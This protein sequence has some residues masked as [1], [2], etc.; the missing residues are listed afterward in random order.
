M[1]C[2]PTCLKIVLKY[3]GKNISLQKLRELSNISREGVSVKSIKDAAEKLGFECLG[4]KLTFDQLKQE[5]ELFPCI[6]HWNQN[7]FVVLYKITKSRVYVS[8]PGIGLINYSHGDFL[9]HWIGNSKKEGVALF[10][11]FDST[12]FN[13]V[14]GKERSPFRFIKRYFTNKKRL[15]VPLVV[16]L[17]IA[18]LIQLVFPFL[19][20][21]IVDTGIKDKNI[22]FIYLI[23]IA[24]LSLIS[25]RYIVEFVR[26]RML[27]HLSTR[28]NIEL[29][30][31]FL[32][33]LMKLP[34]SF[35]DSKVTGDLIQRISD[36]GRIENF[37]SITTLNFI[38]SFTLVFFFGG[39][40]FYYDPLIFFVFISAST[41]YVLY[42]FYFFKK[43]KVLDYKKFQ[44]L[45]S[46]QESLVQIINGMGEIKLNNWQ[47]YK[48]EEW[49]HIQE[50]LY[51]INIKSLNLSQYQNGGGAF[52]RETSNIIIT[53]ISAN[54]VIEGQITLGIMIAIQY[55]VGQLNVP[56]N[57]FLQFSTQ[58]QDA[59]ISLNRINEIHNIEEESSNNSIQLEHDDITFNEL[60]FRYPGTEAVV[61]SR[62]N[63]KVEKGRTTAIVGTSGS[64]KTTLLKLILKFYEPTS[65]E[66]R[67]GSESLAEIDPNEWRSQCGAVMQDGFIFSDTILKNIVGTDEYD[68]IGFKNALDV[69]NLT[70]YVNGLPLK[71]HSKIGSD[72]SSISGGQ[73]Q[74]LLIARAIYKNPNLILFDEATSSLDA[75]NERNIMEKIYQFTESMTVIIVA[76]R[77]STVKRADNIIVL[78]SGKVIEQGKHEDLVKFKGQ[79]YE[80]I[81][82]QLE[83]GD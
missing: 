20:Q 25:G 39:V 13:E 55:I 77:L 80:L 27:I 82:N 83:L 47:A 60:S 21:E 4:S 12:Q 69:A 8:D 57:S 68:P 62:I 49:K 65:G 30:E 73:R 37:F 40:L 19:T 46:N 67:I 61:L 42:V 16:C 58:V 38:F 10:M 18:S 2:G 70:D 63:L 15:I 6:I 43:R 79:Y 78:E 72:G 23:L 44:T 45:S 74:R 50:K 56:L 75:K 48:K 1:D 3:Y 34:F 14:S 53:F 41:L 31:D 9:N 81:K 66:I 52:I 28:I 24:Q 22:R 71:E 51:D 54:A 35:F 76:H 59:S 11:D 33:K 32:G 36:H 7:H 26:D 17:L 29:I 64:G 5:R